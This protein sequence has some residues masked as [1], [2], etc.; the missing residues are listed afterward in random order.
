MGGYSLERFKIHA[1]L[2]DMEG[3]LGTA[4]VLAW[5]LRNEGH[6]AI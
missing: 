6:D 4:E 3:Q 1:G 5:R 2:G